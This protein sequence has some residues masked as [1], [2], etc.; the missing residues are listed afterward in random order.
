MAR[1]LEPLAGGVVLLIT[2]LDVFLTVLYARAGTG[3][4]APLLARGIW[5]GFR[6]LCKG[7]HT[8]CLNYCGPVQL[9]ALVL[10]WSVL[11][12]FGAGLIIHPALGTDV[13]SGSGSKDTDFVTAMFVGGSSMSIVGASDYG[14]ASAGYKVLFLFNSMVGMSVTSLT[15]TYLMQVYTALRS[16]NT[17]GLKMEAQSGQTGNAA[18]VLARWSPRGSLEGVESR[19][20][21]LAGEFAEFKEMYHFYP[22]LFYFRFKEVHYATPRILLVALDTVTLIRTILDPHKAGWLRES[23]ALNELDRTTA[24]LLQTL[25]QAFPVN[26]RKFVASAQCPER[27]RVRY[28]QAQRR[29]QEVGIPTRADSEAG[30]QEY[31]DLRA[32]WEPYIEAHAHTLGYTMEDIDGAAQTSPLAA[33]TSN[34]ESESSS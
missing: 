13:R 24:M 15:L 19:L 25:N 7:R 27:R 5:A 8:G 30:A 18:E 28:E 1:W 34:Q 4:L 32:T 10:M 2:L 20:S 9:V 11:L 26:D 14:P 29:L 21:T 16:R 31:V 3:L 12:A 23:A 6:G 17:V 22:V 33:E